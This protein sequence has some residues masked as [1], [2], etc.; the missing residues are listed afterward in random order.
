MR[1]RN[2]DI[3]LA[4][5]EMVRTALS[6]DDE[7]SLRSARGLE[8]WAYDQRQ[9]IVAEPEF[10]D[11][12]F[13]LSK[14]VIETDVLSEFDY[15]EDGI[16][17]VN[18]LG[19]AAGMCAPILTGGKR[20][21]IRLVSF[22]YVHEGILDWVRS[23]L[24]T[25]AVVQLTMAHVCASAMVE[26]GLGVRWSTSRPGS[27]RRDR[28]DELLLM[29]AEYTKGLGAQTHP[30]GAFTGSET[31]FALAT[32]NATAHTLLATGNDR[33]LTAE[34]PCPI[35]GTIGSILLRVE[36]DHVDS[37][38]GRGALLTTAIPVDPFPDDDAC[39]QALQLNQWT[40]QATPPDFLRGVGAWVSDPRALMYRTF[41]PDFCHRP[42]SLWDWVMYEAKRSMWVCE[43]VY[44][45]DWTADL[46]KQRAACRRRFEEGLKRQPARN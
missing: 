31:S 35:P 24:P 22:T 44:E 1:P 7:W 5:I 11:D 46:E 39:I 32:L 26:R 28:P 21:G 9:R 17:A 14:V 45:V 37:R 6:I 19:M 41:L 38:W 42:Q 23:F 33:G 16:R 34:F 20:L 43:R 25:V 12:E 27:G 8:W 4:A 30:D 2:S 36:S 40:L 3:G 18:D 10:S 13:V 29:G 15:S